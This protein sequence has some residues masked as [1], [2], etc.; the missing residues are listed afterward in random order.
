M[1]DTNKDR[2]MFNYIFIPAGSAVSRDGEML[3]IKGATEGP[4]LSFPYG[5]T[6]ILDV[7]NSLGDG[8]IDHHQPGTEDQCVASMIADNPDKWVGKYLK[9]SKSYS[10]VTHS[11]PDFD[12]LGSVYL[13]EKYIREMRLPDIA[14]A[15]GAYV[16]QV[17]SGKKMLD[18]KRLVEP[19]SLVL[20]ISETVRSDPSI[21]FDEKYL[22]TLIVTFRLFDSIFQILSEGKS[23]E[24][25]DWETLS[26]FHNEIS[27]I[28]E[29]VSAY[30]EDL[31]TRSQIRQIRLRHGKSLEVSMVDCL[32]TNFPQS[33]LWKYWA[34]GDIDYSSGHNG[35]IMTVAFLP[36]ENTR[37]IIAVDPNTGYSL[38]GLGLYLDY[39]EMRKLLVANALENIIGNKRAGFHRENPWYDGRSSMHNFTIIDV[40]RGGSLLSEREIM[41]AVLKTDVWSSAFCDQDFENV[42]TE[43]IVGFFD[44]RT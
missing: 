19:F 7:G 14:P 44:E 39:L 15:F 26:G 16:L 43:E 27:L 38:K 1:A 17:D 10:L 20:A 24:S 36:S 32:I 33:I 40:P 4:V 6:F 35:F 25:F 34:R 9:E 2:V 3:T 30:G 29:D 22:K 8:V 42:S 13:A 23:I 31:K 11:A 28:K 18:K 41:E 21:P 5:S 37:A 12:A